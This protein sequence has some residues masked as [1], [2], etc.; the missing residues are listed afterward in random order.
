MVDV[1]TWDEQEESD[2]IKKKKQTGAK[3][4]KRKKKKRNRKINKSR[5]SPKEDV[6]LS[7]TGSKVDRKAKKEARNSGKKT[8]KE[9]ISMLEDQSVTFSDTWDDELLRAQASLFAKHTR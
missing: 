4:C 7:V 9:L 3:R 2:A 1:E 6:V 8:R 5:K